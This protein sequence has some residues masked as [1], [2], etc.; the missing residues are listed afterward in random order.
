LTLV[1]YHVLEL[2]NMTSVLETKR[3]NNKGQSVDIIDGYPKFKILYS[4]DEV[5]KN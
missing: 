3:S 2:K 4:S 5:T 1:K